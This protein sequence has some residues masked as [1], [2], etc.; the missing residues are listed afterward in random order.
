MRTLTKKVNDVRTRFSRIINPKYYEYFPALTS[1]DIGCMREEASQNNRI[2]ESQRIILWSHWKDL[3][4]NQWTD[5][6]FHQNLRTCLSVCICI[7]ICI[8][9]FVSIFV[10]IMCALLH[11]SSCVLQRVWLMAVCLFLC[12]CMRMIGTC[13]NMS[14]CAIGADFR[15]I[16]LL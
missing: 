9:A 8:Y 16:F 1:I 14:M 10:S 12:L 2:P 5:P 15:P 13:Q 11:L 7:C 4:R 3:R 6:C